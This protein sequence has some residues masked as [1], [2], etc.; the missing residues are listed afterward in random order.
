VH[1]VPSAV[2]DQ[3]I[4]LRD[5]NDSIKMF[6][7]HGTRP[8]MRL[9]VVSTKRS[10]TQMHSCRSQINFLDLLLNTLQLLPLFVSVK[11][12]NYVHV[13]RLPGLVK[14]KYCH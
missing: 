13:L 12:I 1:P 2:E 11:W 14:Q 3:S 5:S 7:A 8:Y 6:R 4:Q 9:A 10:I